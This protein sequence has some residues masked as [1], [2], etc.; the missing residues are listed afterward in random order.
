MKLKIVPL[1]VVKE[2]RL[3]GG[4]FFCQEWFVMQQMIPTPASLIF[5]VS[6]TDKKEHSLTL[7]EP[8]QDLPFVCFQACECYKGQPRDKQWWETGASS[9]KQFHENLMSTSSLLK[10]AIKPLPT[11]ILVPQPQTPTFPRRE[12]LWLSC[13]M[14]NLMLT[15]SCTHRR[16]GMSFPVSCVL[17]LMRTY[18][19]EVFWTQEKAKYKW[20]KLFHLLVRSAFPFYFF[21][22]CWAF[23]SIYTP[24][25]EGKK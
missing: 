9:A 16:P 20:S 12:L 17:L 23:G 13:T 25:S 4:C 19:A 8:Q 7:L 21:F 1:A 18:R 3:T 22:R 11:A 5:I 10:A 15:G 14:G 2:I 6:L 24:K